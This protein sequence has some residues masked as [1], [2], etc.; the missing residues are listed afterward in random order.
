[1]RF[2]D[3][4][5]EAF[6]RSLHVLRGKRPLGEMSW[7]LAQGHVIDRKTGERVTWRPKPM[8]LAVNDVLRAGEDYERA[9][10]AAQAE[11]DLAFAT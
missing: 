2:V 4:K 6:V 5:D 8:L 3:P 9:V 7:A 10:R 11:L 1:M